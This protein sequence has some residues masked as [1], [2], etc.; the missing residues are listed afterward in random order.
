MQRA[1]KGHPVPFAYA[2]VLV[3]FNHELLTGRAEIL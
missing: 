2:E 3:T 1:N